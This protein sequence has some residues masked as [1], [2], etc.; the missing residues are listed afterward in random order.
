MPGPSPLSVKKG[1]SAVGLEFTPTK[2]Q[3]GLKRT[4][5]RTI[6]PIQTMPGF[7]WCDDFFIFEALSFRLWKPLLPWAW[8]G[9]V[10]LVR[11]LEFTSPRPDPIHFQVTA[12][13][14]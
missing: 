6:L 4:R 12:N 13:F 10:G 9:A 7:N 8:Q 1:D 11:H 5:K 2:G 14:D 3:P